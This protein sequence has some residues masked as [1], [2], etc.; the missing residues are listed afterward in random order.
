MIK[1]RE[2]LRLV[3]E[4]YQL[5]PLGVHGVPHWGRVLEN[6]R[7]LCALTGADPVVIEMF[8][9]FHDA[10]RR[11]DAWDPDHGPRAADLARR[12]RDRLG[13][14]DGQFA[15][16]ITAC[17]GHTVGPG[18]DADITVLTCLDADR[19]DI[20]RVGMRIKPELLFTGAGRSPEMLSWA[21][22]RAAEQLLPPVCA[23]E[24]DWQP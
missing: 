9:L 7:R 18:E 22:A 10:C 15:Q 24:W 17:H 23:D 13:L 3:L 8:S 21:G 11:N 14:D 2:L 19:L 4:Q 1:P 6:G 16:L 12:F 5:S 20:P